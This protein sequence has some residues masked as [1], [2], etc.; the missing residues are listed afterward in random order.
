MKERLYYGDVYKRINGKNKLI[1]SHVLLIKSKECDDYLI[2]AKFRKN[3]KL[4]L[5]DNR[6][7]RNLNEGLNTFIPTFILRDGYY[8]IDKN[9][10]EPYCTRKYTLIKTV[11][12]D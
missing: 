2:Y 4:L 10:I 8:F 11:M 3:P 6:E 9:S 12:K 7:C 1:K 5:K